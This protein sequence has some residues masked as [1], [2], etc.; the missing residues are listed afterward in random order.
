M[1][2]RPRMICWIS[3][4]TILT[5]T[6]TTALAAP[7]PAHAALPGAAVSSAI[8]PFD[9]EPAK[10]AIAFCGEGKRVTGGGGRITG[11]GHVVMTRL[12]PVHTNNRDRFEVSAAEDEIGTD[13]T[14]SVQAFAVCADALPGQEIVSGTAADDGSSSQSAIAQCPDGKRAISGGGRITGGQ[15]Q[16]HLSAVR[17]APTLTLAAGQEDSTGFA[18]SW[19]VTAYLVCAS[20]DPTTLRFSEFTSGSNSDSPKFESTSCGTIVG[21]RVTGGGFSIVA[22]NAAGDVV[23]QAVLPEVL[24]G[25][26]PGTQVRVIARENNPTDEIWRVSAGASCAI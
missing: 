17:N 9:S 20:V 19:T 16:V 21:F 25:G 2:T 22:P 14:W 10:T 1:R 15:G 24:I 18:G 8:T 12:Q 4:A 13:E 23:I 26:V 11:P 7:T 6:A 3:A 5:A